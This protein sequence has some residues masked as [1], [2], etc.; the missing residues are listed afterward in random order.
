MFCWWV[1]THQSLE[2]KRYTR[3]KT[4]VQTCVQAR[5]SSVDKR[6]TAFQSMI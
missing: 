2:A 3:R 6:C 4:S 1:G 5:R